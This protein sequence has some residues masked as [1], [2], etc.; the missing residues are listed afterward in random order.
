VR[1]YESDELDTLVRKLLLEHRV[2]TAGAFDDFMRLVNTVAAAA[3]DDG[4]ERGR[5]RLSVAPARTTRSDRCD[6]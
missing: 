5:G 6:G 4:Y 3:F 1:E 2:E